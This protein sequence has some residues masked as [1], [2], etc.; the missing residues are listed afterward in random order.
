MTVA[1]IMPLLTGSV[2]I[3]DAEAAPLF[4]GSAGEYT[5]YKYR[6]KLD[7]RELVRIAPEPD[8]TGLLLVCK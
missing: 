7:R 3:Y 2:S 8:G 6:Y 4:I 1:D 5:G